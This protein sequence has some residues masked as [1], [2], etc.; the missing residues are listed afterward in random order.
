MK[1]T[2][3]TVA[4]ATITLLS[5]SATEFVNINSLTLENGNTKAVLERFSTYNG[6]T[7]L[8]TQVLSF[9][10]NLNMQAVVAKTAMIADGYVTVTGK[11][12]SS[13]VGQVQNL[14]TKR[15]TAWYVSLAAYFIELNKQISEIGLN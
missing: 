10:G 2:I 9:K 12:A 11:G 3:L 13:T 15:A 6:T 5:A 8:G 14:A 4:I 7:S 1:K